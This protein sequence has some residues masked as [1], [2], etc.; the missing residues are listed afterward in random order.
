MTVV[1][2]F[3]AV[4]ALE[5]RARLRVELA[6]KQI[7]SQELDVACTFE[8][9]GVLLCPASLGEGARIQGRLLNDVVSVCRSHSAISSAPLTVLGVFNPSL[10]SELH[11]HPSLKDPNVYSTFPGPRKIART[12]ASAIRA[13][14][15]VEGSISFA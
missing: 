11:Q 9:D 4:S 5:V 14:P 3:A 13:L 12:I 10:A 8:R 15:A 6:E 1:L 7:V 2:E